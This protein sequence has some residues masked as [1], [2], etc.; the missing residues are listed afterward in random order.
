MWLS[1]DVVMGVFSVKAVVWNPWD[2]TKRAE[3]EL[4]VDTGATYSVLPSSLL[5]RLDIEPIRRVRLR[6]ADGRTTEK[7]LGEIGIEIENIFVSATPVVFG[8]EGIYLLGSVTME[9]LGVAPDPVERRLKPI[10]ALLMVARSGT[11][12]RAYRRY[13][14]RVHTYAS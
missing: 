6:L 11:P 1:G 14:L 4:L 2:R 3:V 8:E 13:A 9:Q 12:A 10:E 7:P 5:K